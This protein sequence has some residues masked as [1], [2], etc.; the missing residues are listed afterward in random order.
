VTDYY[1]DAGALVK[2]YAPELSSDW[3]LEIT[4]PAAEHTAIL[5]EITLAEVAAALAAKQQTPSGLTL[6]ERDRALSRFLQD[7]AESFLPLQVDRSVIDRAVELTQSY[8]LRAHDAVQL[9]T[10]LIAND[11]LVEQEHPPLVFVAS[12]KDFLAPAQAEGLKVDNPA[13]H[14]TSP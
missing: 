13:R 4:D 7:C 6:E 9:A 2:R 11:D 3:V 14:L 10:A 1:L 8:R 12:D 5:S